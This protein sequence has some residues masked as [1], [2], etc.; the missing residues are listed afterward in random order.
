MTT[1]ATNFCNELHRR[2]CCFVLISF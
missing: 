1:A 2:N